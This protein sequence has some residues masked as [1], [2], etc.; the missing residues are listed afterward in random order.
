[1]GPGRGGTDV[2]WDHTIRGGGSGDSYLPW[3][4]ATYCGPLL[5][6]VAPAGLTEF[7]GELLYLVPHSIRIPIELFKNSEKNPSGS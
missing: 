3:P 5:L 6:T 2:T 7:G 1:M 4:I